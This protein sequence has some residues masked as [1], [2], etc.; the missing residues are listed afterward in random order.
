MRSQTIKHKNNNK[1]RLVYNADR[2][3]FIEETYDDQ[4][5]F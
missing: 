3:V 1:K 2:D 4:I 5:D